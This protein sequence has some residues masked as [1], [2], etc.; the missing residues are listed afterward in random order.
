MDAI[1]NVARCKHRD[2]YD[3]F[4]R[5]QLKICKS[6]KES[7]MPTVILIETTYSMNSSVRKY[8]VEPYKPL[9]SAVSGLCTL[10]D[11]IGHSSRL[12]FVCLVSSTATIFPWIRWFTVFVHCFYFT[13]LLKCSIPNFLSPLTGDLLKPI[14]SPRPVHARSRNDQNRTAQH[15]TDG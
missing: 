3:Q 4:F 14:G 15:P 5:L 6:P 10:L 12:E 7:K 11:Q 1:L 9:P 8:N 13:V 2:Y